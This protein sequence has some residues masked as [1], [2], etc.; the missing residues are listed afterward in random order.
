MATQLDIYFNTDTSDQPLGTSA[1]EWT[2]LD[3]DNDSLLFTAGS[4]VVK[5]GEALPSAT[6]LNNAGIRLTGVETIV[7][8]YL[9]SDFDAN[10]LKEVNLMGDQNSRYVMAFDFDGPTASEPVM[11]LW[12]DLNLNSVDLISLGAGVPSNSYFQ[13]IVT[14]FASSGPSGWV[15]TR[16]AGGSTGHFLNLNDGNGPL[17]SAGT[18]YCNIKVVIPASANQSGAEAPVFAVKYTTN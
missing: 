2:L 10:E 3:T 12:D 8:V 13:G 7:N 9:M 4:D 6:Q 11:E 14:T 18:L 16:L 17:A 15:G 1:V 5:D